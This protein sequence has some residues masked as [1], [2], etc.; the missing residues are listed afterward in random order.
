MKADGD[1]QF[2]W[3]VKIEQKN[4][5]KASALSTSPHT[6]VLSSNRVVKSALYKTRFVGIS[7]F[8]TRAETD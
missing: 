4:E 3:S 1:T 6:A 8:V 5:E 7:G 2:E